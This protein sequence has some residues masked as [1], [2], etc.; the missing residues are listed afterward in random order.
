MWARYVLVL[1]LV[2]FVDGAAVHVRDL[3]RDGLGAYGF[4][5]LA[6]RVFFVGLVVL[7]PLVV[8]LLVAVPWYGIL[9]GGAVM[10]VDVAANWYVNRAVLGDCCTALG[11]SPGLV[12][13]TVFALFVLVSV[14]PLFHSL[15]APGA[16]EPREHR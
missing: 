7:D 16:R 12:A 2:G 6:V 14:V 8:A 5:P 10:V 15:S 11:H 3:V 13:I 4:A 9:L 1:Y